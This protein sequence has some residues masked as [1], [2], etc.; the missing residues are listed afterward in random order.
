MV[1]DIASHQE[2]SRRLEETSIVRE[3][4]LSNESTTRAS[5]KEFKIDHSISAIMLGESG[6]KDEKRVEVV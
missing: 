6:V 5:G 3:V 2:E 4:R 1:R